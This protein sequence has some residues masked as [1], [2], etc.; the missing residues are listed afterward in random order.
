MNT[1]ISNSKK[2]GKYSVRYKDQ[3]RGDK[4]TFCDKCTSEHEEGC[5]PAKG[6]SC[7]VCDEENH[8]ARSKAYKGKDQGKTAKKVTKSG[9]EEE[10]FYDSREEVRQIIC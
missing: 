6:K 2:A 3:G 5:C 10:E 9:K 1:A 4:N 8:F 7:F